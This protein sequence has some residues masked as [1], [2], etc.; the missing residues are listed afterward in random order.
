MSFF[1]PSF[2]AL[3]I[4]SSSSSYPPPYLL[5]S[6][7]EMTVKRTLFFFLL[8]YDN[9]GHKRTKVV[10]TESWV[11]QKEKPSLFRA[12]LITSTETKWRTIGPF[13][14]LVH[15]GGTCSTLNFGYTVTE[16]VTG[17]HR[18]GPTRSS[19]TWT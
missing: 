5:S 18:V 6:R 17:C 16:G 4:M 3:F 14:C 19:K 10:A 9:S 7:T 13:H 11:V 15:R 2:I 1:F 12:V 8:S